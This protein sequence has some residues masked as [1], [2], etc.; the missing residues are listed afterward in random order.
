LWERF[1]HKEA[2]CSTKAQ[3][4]GNS[5]SSHNNR[6]YT[7]NS[8]IR[9]NNT[10]NYNNSGRNYNRNFY[11]NRDLNQNRRNRN[12]IN[13]GDNPSGNNARGTGA[14]RAQSGLNAIEAE[15]TDTKSREFPFFTAE[16]NVVDVNAMENAVTTLLKSCVQ[17]KLFNQ[18]EQPCNNRGSYY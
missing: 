1:G 18:P 10:S 3:D 14:T 8:N 15:I 13:S 12:N 7:G 17:M 2:E 11:K 6:A 5:R 4:N 16:N 9:S